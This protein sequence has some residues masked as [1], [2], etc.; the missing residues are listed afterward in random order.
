MTEIRFDEWLEELNRIEEEA[1][2]GV[3][4]PQLA[5]A[6]GHS[7]EWVRRRLR[8][9]IAAGTVLP[10]QVRRIGMDSRPCVVS[11]YRIAT[12]APAK[13]GKGKR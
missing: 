8:P 2:D 12:K 1:G 9:A 11:A 3:T 7:E 6:C 13:N 10:V 5:V 4:V